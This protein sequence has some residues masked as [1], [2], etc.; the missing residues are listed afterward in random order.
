MKHSAWQEYLL[1]LRSPAVIGPGTRA[2]LPPAIRRA[3]HILFMSL[4]FFGFYLLARPIA[5]I[6]TSLTMDFKVTG[7]H[8]I[9]ADR[10]FIGT[11]NHLSNFDPLIGTLVSPRPMYV[12]VK[13]EYFRTPVLGGIAIALGGFPVRRGEA[14]RQAI[15]TSL[16]IVKR[17]SSLAI[18]PEGT[19]SK[20][21]KLQNG[22][23]GAA[24]IAASADMPVLPAALWG[25]EN[26]M[27]RRKFG[28]LTRPR[29]YFAFGPVYILKEEAAA[30][31]A[32]HGLP[33]M[34]KRGRHDD[35]DFLSDVMM[36]KIAELLPAE[37]RGDFTPAEVV[38]RY[39]RRLQQK[40]S[41]QAEKPVV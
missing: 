1:D 17:G 4:R 27:R 39:S 29:V 2:N 21:Y 32:R 13:A 25:T 12:M 41:A 5:W 23:P 40:T 6:I 33:A 19:R 9:P 20:T 7:R 31:A 8:N 14:D 11:C 28:W 15:K 22:Q 38:A 35:L 37:Y 16:S 24:M 34:G 36:L 10:G 18:Y 26:L 30:F 3:A